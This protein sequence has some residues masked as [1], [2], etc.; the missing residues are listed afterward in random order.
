VP[1]DYS[2]MTEADLQA[3]L[4]DANRRKDAARDEARAITGHLDALR[5]KAA[6]HAKVAGL[7]PAERS[8]L[9]LRDAAARP[10]PIDAGAAAPRPAGR[11]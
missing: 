5:V 7:S 8:A 4:N 10:A 6:A 2:T 1:T 3:A 11:T 9:G